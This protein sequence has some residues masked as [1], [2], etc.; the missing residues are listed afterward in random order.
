MI[1]RSNRPLFERPV[2]SLCFLEVILH[3][4]VIFLSTIYIRIY[5]GV[6][7]LAL[8]KSS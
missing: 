6:R 7:K 1:E 5:E 4:V 3:M 2:K 8:L